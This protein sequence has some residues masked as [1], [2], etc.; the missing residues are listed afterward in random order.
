MEGSNV[1]ELH[2]LGMEGNQFEYK[3]IVGNSKSVEVE[4]I[5]IVGWDGT[6]SELV[7]FNLVEGFESQKKHQFIDEKVNKM[8]C[9]FKPSRQY[10]NIL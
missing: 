3:N 5:T 4:E 10:E 9:S 8:G 7:Y 1:T 2:K 6:A